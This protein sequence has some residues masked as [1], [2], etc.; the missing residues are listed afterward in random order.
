MKINFK[1]KKEGKQSLHNS[2]KM[3]AEVLEE[4]T[5]MMFYSM[6]CSSRYVKGR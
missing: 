4:Q 1:E 2:K 3:K 6:C 5:F